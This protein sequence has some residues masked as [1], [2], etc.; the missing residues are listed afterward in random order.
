MMANAFTTIADIFPPAERG[1]YMGFMTGVFGVAAILGPLL[2]GLIT[3]GISWHWIFY[4]NVP[5]AIPVL[6]LFIKYFPDAHVQRTEH[7]IDYLGVL[8]LIS[9]VVPLLIGLAGRT[10]S[11]RGAL[12]R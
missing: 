7:N 4:V 5:I 10:W 8:L 11:T 12:C 9:G 6:F 2:G 3:D 1:K